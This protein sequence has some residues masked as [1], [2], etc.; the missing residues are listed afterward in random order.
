MAQ[1]LILIYEDEAAWSAASPAEL[2]QRN[3]RQRP[4]GQHHRHLDPQRHRH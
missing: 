2:A 1:Y 3:R 4:S